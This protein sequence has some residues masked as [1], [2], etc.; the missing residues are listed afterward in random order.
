M[1]SRSTIDLADLLP[2]TFTAPELTDEQ[3][4]AL[5][6]K[7]PDATLEYTEEGEVI[8]MPPTDPLS[9]ARVGLVTHRL[10]A[11]SERSGRGTVSGPDGGFRLP[12]H[13]R[14]SPD[15]A[16][17]EGYPR[18]AGSFPVFAPQFVIEVRSPHDR[19]S[20]LQ[21]KMPRYIAAGVQLAWLID[22]FGK[23]VTIYRPDREP[24]I[25]VNPTSVAGEGPVQGFE[26]DLKGIL[27]S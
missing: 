2:A 6:E 19:L 3:F 13:A 14:R 1:A 11:W 4:L 5:C 21:D 10:I 16:W 18:S 8:V 23:T 20:R 9:S 27:D 25:L 22:P 7:F 12:S 15:A 17:F 26:L 24:E